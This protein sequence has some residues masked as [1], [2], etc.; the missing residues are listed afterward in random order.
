MSEDPQ[1]PSMR[2]ASNVMRAARNALRRLPQE[3]ESADLITSCGNE[4]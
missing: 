2:D 1:V 3:T 4:Q